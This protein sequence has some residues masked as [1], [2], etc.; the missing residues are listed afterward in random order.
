MKTFTGPR[1][2]AAIA[3]ATCLLFLWWYGGR[4]EPM[5]AAAVERRLSDIN[6]PTTGAPQGVGQA[7]GEIIDD[8]R[9]L[10][11]SDYG[12]QFFMLNLIRYRLKALYPP[13]TR[14]D[15]DALAAEA[16]YSRAL[17]PYLLKYGG[18]PVFIGTP[19]CRFLDQAGDTEWQRIAIVRCRG[20]AA[21]G[22]GAGAASAV[23]AW[24][25]APAACAMS[26]GRP[27]G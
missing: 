14:F 16:R 17:A 18:V 20:G 11:A 7:K 26:R 4:G 27:F 1:W 8:L 13:G 5:G 15:D 6:A 23:T 3:I 12:N 22:H 24:A 9:R 19:R 10:A 2:L 25:L 21:G